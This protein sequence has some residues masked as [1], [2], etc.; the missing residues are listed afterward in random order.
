MNSSLK[1]VAKYSTL[2]FKQMNDITADLYNTD[3]EAGNIG[4]LEAISKYST[5]RAGDAGKVDIDA[6]NDK[7]YLGN[8]GDIHLTDKYSILNVLNAG[9]IK[10][11]CYNSTVQLKSAEDVEVISKY[12]KYE[13]GGAHN[14]NI[15]S[16]FNDTYRIEHLESLNVNDSKYAVYKIE[17]LEH[18]LLL[19][20]GYSDKI[21]VTETGALKELKVNG[22][23]VSVEMALD[24]G[25]DYRF[26]ADVKYGKLDI[27]E[28]AMIVKRKIKEGPALEMEAIK[29][30]EREGMPSFFVNGYDMAVTLTG[31]L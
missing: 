21:Q 31:E 5:F 30:V 3:V 23:Y 9:H 2:E 10:L 4:N 17:H 29:G 25:L 6:Y 13:M 24:K 18:S 14:L 7:Y 11:D 1:V 28:E 20:E 19:K 27:N 22:K 15:I 16:A 12:G 26:F 8:T